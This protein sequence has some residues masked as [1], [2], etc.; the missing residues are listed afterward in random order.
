M[1]IIASLL[2]VFLFSSFAFALP[3]E[4][5][6]T[7]INQYQTRDVKKWND[8]GCPIL[9]QT[10]LGKKTKRVVSRT[11]SHLAKCMTSCVFSLQMY[12]MYDE[13]INR[14]MWIVQW[15]VPVF[16]TPTRARVI[17]DRSGRALRW[18]D[19][20]AKYFQDVSMFYFPG[21]GRAY[22]WFLFLP[23]L[24]WRLAVGWHD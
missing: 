21:D 9:S 2:S 20:E 1:Q 7:S 4:E 13:K 18:Q 8:N 6:P 16:G 15:S 17:W 14:C 12:S 11:S 3:L 5:A 19:K 22:L 10:K 23:P 24:D